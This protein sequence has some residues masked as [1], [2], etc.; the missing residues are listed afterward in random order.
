MHMLAM[1][2]SN[3]SSCRQL[4]SCL[5]KCTPQQRQPHPSAATTWSS[6]D[7]TCASSSGGNLKRVQ[8]DCRAGMIFE[9]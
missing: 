6:R 8:R 2:H 1:S 5:H 3:S 9:T 7:R 4:V